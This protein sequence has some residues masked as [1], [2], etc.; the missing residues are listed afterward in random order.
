M[1]TVGGVGGGTEEDAVLSREEDASD[2]DDDESPPKLPD[3][4]EGGGRN[5][6]RPGLLG[7][8]ELSLVWKSSD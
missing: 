8:S 1:S 7:G 6:E 4:D 3:V 2:C 5:G